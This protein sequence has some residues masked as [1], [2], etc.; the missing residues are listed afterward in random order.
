MPVSKKK[1]TTSLPNASTRPSSSLVMPDQK[2]EKLVRQHLYEKAYAA[3]ALS[4]GRD[5]IL[6]VCCLQAFLWV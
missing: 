1:G 3:L 5:S 4:P 2:L 6:C